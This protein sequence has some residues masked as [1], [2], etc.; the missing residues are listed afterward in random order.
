M[1]WGVTLMS[2]L[3]WGSGQVAN[4]QKIKGLWSDI[5]KVWNE[6]AEETN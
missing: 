2:A 1:R 6:A 4:K 3:V 5:K